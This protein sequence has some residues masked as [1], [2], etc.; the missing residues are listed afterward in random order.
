MSYFPIGNSFF[1]YTGEWNSFWTWSCV[2]I[3][4]GKMKEVFFSNKKK[5][6]LQ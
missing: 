2:R 6:Y 3:R 5:G 4:K 1:F